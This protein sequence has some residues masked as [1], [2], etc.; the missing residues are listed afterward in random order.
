MTIEYALSSPFSNR[1]S[2]LR[3]VLD[4]GTELRCTVVE[5][6][7]EDT[8]AR[9]LEL[10]VRVML[11]ARGTMGDWRQSKSGY[12]ALVGSIYANLYANDLK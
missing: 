1:A 5:R 10:H 6:D 3:K 9:G 8:G 4:E 7:N 11:A 2:G 12:P